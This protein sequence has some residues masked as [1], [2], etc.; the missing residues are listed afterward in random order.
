[1]SPARHWQHAIQDTQHAESIATRAQQ[2]ARI[3][4]PIGPTVCYACKG[5]ATKWIRSASQ[6]FSAP[7]CD[8]CGATLVAMFQSR[9][10]DDVTVDAIRRSAER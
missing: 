2:I 4:Q 9:G 8:G 6:H 10:V 3:T 7:R 5:V 1:M